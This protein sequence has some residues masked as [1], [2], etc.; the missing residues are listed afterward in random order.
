LRREEI[1]PLLG[2]IPGGESAYQTVGERSLRV[3]WKLGDGSFLA[4]LANLGPGPLAGVVRPS[5][6]LLYASDGVTDDGRELP[7]WSVLWYL[8][9]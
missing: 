6:R 3:R 5:G 1:L 2:G 8:M 9:G 7:G 4:L